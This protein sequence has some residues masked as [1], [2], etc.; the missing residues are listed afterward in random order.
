MKIIKEEK[1]YRET[2]VR[3][4]ERINAEGDIIV[5]DKKPDVLKILQI[6]ARSVVG[7][8]GITAGGFYVRGKVYI[9]ILYL[10]D[11]ETEETA[12][13]QTVLDFRTKADNSQIEDEMNL[14]I[15]NDVTKLDFILLNSRKLSVKATVN[16]AY[17]AT[18]EKCIEIPTGF[19]TDGME[20][21]T[22][23]A[24]LEEIGAEEEYAFS[25]RGSIEIPAGAESV[26]EIIKTDVRIV[27]SE[28]K[29]VASNIVIDG[30]MGVG[31]LYF[32]KDK[33]IE[34][35]EGEITFTEV[36]ASDGILESDE[37]YSEFS[38]GGIETDVFEDIDGDMRAVGVE[39]LAELSVRTMRTEKIE[40]ISD[41]YCPG[42]N[43]KFDCS[44]REIK[45]HICSFDKENS[46]RLTVAASENVP[47]I[48]R[49]YNV[50]A[51]SE[52]TDCHVAD[53]GVSVGGK[54]VFYISYLSPDP[55]CA[56]YSVRKEE[57]F[58]YY[59][60][61]EDIKEGMECVTKTEIS[62]INYSLSKN[63]EVEIKY[64]V[65]E[66]IRVCEKR[67]ESLIVEVEYEE[68]TDCDDIIICFANK[69]DTLFDIG[70]RYCVSQEAVREINSLENE[71]ILSGQKLLIP[72]C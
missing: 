4:S 31:V 15:A 14:K 60:S 44:E 51:E 42:Q 56:V 37:L 50:T 9:N 23:S 64:C 57:P 25:V 70:K 41:C 5:P 30:T 17:E 28:I 39:C 62:H 47:P 72:L 27:E 46:E 12:C 38:I 61:N 68:K 33:K 29:A 11:T 71:E 8:K 10:T 48:G 49:I 52:I 36:F 67:K 24:Q 2:A 6:D 26:G 66:K 53:G 65:K 34:Y 13:I 35:S 45:I 7:D 32:T 16:I 1:R 3:G 21:L 63:N 54:T 18:R 40:Y 19:E 58:E 69:N 43:T 22:R 59:H 20:C 55:K